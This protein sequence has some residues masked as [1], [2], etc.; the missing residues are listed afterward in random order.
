MV[1]KE[2]DKFNAYDVC[3]PRSLRSEGF[4]FLSKLLKSK[5]PTFVKFPNKKLQFYLFLNILIFWVL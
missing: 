5:L 3:N 4:F 1:R 2:S